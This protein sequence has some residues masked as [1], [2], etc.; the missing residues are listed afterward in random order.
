[1][2]K[3]NTQYWSQRLQLRVFS[4]KIIYFSIE[5]YNLVDF[6]CS[7]FHKYV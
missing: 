3:W 2:N 4:S 1:M 5:A 7:N 6:L